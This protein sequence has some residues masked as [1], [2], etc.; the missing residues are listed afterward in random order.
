M[1]IRPIQPHDFP[2]WLALWNANNLGHKDEAVTT[3]TWARLNDEHMPVHAL[4]AEDQGAL[5]GLVQYVVHPTTGSIAHICYMQDVF[6]DPDHRGKGI[7]RAMIKHL[8]RIAKAEKWARLYW[9]AEETN[10]AAQAL[11]K[12]LGQRVNFTIHMIPTNT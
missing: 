3:E 5:V 11:Y 2:Q 4:V 1:N 6:V 7:A 9:I 10:V 8:E 12:T